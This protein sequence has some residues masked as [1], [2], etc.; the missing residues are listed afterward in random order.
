MPTPLGVHYNSFNEIL[1]PELRAL[2]NETF[3]L[4]HRGSYIRFVTL[5]SFGCH[6]ADVTCRWLCKSR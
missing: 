1:K 4:R 2:G 3:C 5:T 6:V